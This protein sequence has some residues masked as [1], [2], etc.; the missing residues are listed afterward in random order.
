MKILRA[1]AAG[2][3]LVIATACSD[4]RGIIDPAA[5][6]PATRT[7]TMSS[8]AAR[9]VETSG[10]FVAQVD[11]STLTLTPRGSNCLLRVNG[12]LVF[13]GTITGTGVGQ[14]S[15]LVSARCADVATNPPGTFSDVFK[16]E[17]TFT[18]TIG[19]VPV[20]ADMRY[21]GR[22][23]EGGAIE[24]HIVLSN[25]AAGVLNTN[26]VIVAVGGDYSGQVVVP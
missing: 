24:A 5:S 26:N 13:T 17:L 2:A 15:A 10:A 9:R 25:G 11:F 6:A 23:Q 22:V 14:T 4:G 12:Q 21:I 7:R 20:T 18:G 1:A 8:E 16:S 19:G 3:T